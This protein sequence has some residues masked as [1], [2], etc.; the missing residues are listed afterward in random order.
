MAGLASDEEEKI[1]SP[2]KPSKPARKSISVPFK[3]Q[4][5]Y[6][7]SMLYQSANS[8]DRVL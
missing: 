2:I 6:R 7:Y 1:K 4:K 5:K 8:Q 3:K